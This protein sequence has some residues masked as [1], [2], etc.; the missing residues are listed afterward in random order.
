MSP[1]IPP[2]PDKGD[3]N[4]IG[5]YAAVHGRPAAFEGCDGLS[6][7]VEIFTDSTGEKGK[8]FGAYFLFVRWNE[9]ADPVVTGHIETDFLEYGTTAHEAR[10]RL[11][12]MPLA[13]VKQLLDRSIRERRDQSVE[14]KWWDVMRDGDNV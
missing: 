8:P 3:A 6:Y 14:R 7:S 1:F 4:T 12:K 5:G 10:A 13:D 11:G 9:T 2:E